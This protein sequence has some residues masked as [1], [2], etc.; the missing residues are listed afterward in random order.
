MADIETKTFDQPDEVR[1]APKARMESV[2][3]N[4]LKAWR[5]VFEPGWRFSEHIDP[6]L[7]PAP[8]AAY[9]VSGRLRIR[10]NDGT[11]AEVGAGA[12]VV[13]QPGH[14]AWTVGDEPC[15]WIDFAESLIQARVEA[16]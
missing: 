7:C 9:V 5:L 16:T 6:N 3:V 4:G 15:V 2:T 14:D 1:S 10:A 13:L 11:E 12:I 8:H